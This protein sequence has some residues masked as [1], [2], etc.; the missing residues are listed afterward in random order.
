MGDKS[1]SQYGQAWFELWRWQ[2]CKT[3]WGV[4]Q[5]ISRA[6]LVDN[7]WKNGWDPK[8]EAKK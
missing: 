1:G 7:E 3:F 8:G 4:A 5:D 2:H 6:R